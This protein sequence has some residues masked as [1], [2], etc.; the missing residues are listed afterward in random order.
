MSEKTDA[1]Y[2]EVQSLWRHWPWLVVLVLGLAGLFWFV[3]VVQILQGSPVGARPGSDAAVLGLWGA[4]GVLVPLFFL[5]VHLR[6]EVQRDAL[7]FRFFP[8]LRMRRIP[9]E[10]IKEC[11]VVRYR[12]ILDYLGWGIRIGSHGWAY[13]VRGSRGVE[14]IR[15]DGSR[16]ILGSQMPEE[17][18]AALGN[19][20][21]R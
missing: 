12:P 20:K 15:E 21:G 18:A 11:R 8:L 19:A 1:L 17:L 2:R 4:F 5:A 16:F 13:T 3:F 6:I 7:C 10:E 14:I 9:L